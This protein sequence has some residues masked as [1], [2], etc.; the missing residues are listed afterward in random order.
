MD[1]QENI[2][3]VLR[4]KNS[5]LPMIRRRVQQD[6]LEREFRESLDMASE[7]LD[8]SYQANNGVMSLERFIE[9]T[10]SILIDGIHYEIYSTTPLDSEWY[11]DVIRSLKNHFRTRIIARYF[12]ITRKL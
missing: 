12:Q 11:D 7:M 9:V 8:R 4:E 2:R 10:T 1:L 3:K 5:L 6:D